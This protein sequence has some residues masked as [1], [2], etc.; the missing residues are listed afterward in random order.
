MCSLFECTSVYYTIRHYWPAAWLA[1]YTLIMK[2]LYTL[3]LTLATAYLFAQPCNISD[4]TAQVS[5]CD[6]NGQFSVTLKFFDT[7]IDTK[8]Y[9]IQGNGLNYGIFDYNNGIVITGLDGDCTT[10]YDFIVRDGTNPNCGASVEV[11]EICCGPCM[12]DVAIKSLGECVDDDNYLVEFAIDNAPINSSGYSVSFNGTTVAD[13]A[14]NDPNPVIEIKHDGEEFAEFIICDRD[15][16]TCCDSIRIVSPCVCNISNMQWDI[17]DCNEQDSTFS[18]IFSADYQV[19]SDSFTIGGNA[20]NY[21]RFAY[22]QLPLVLGPFTWQDIKYDFTIADVNNLFCF[23]FVEPGIVDI[24]PEEC[25]WQSTS[26]VYSC[27]EEDDL[28]VTVSIDNP[29]SGVLGYEVGIGG[30]FTDTLYTRDTAYSL[31]IADGFCNGAPSLIL[32]DLYYSCDTTIQLADS[33]CRLPCDITAL[34]AEVDCDSEELTINLTTTASDTRPAT[35]VLIIGGSS[36]TIATGLVGDYPL[37]IDIS[38]Y[39]NDSYVLE[40]YVDTDLCFD[41]VQFMIDCPFECTFSTVTAMVGDC[42]SQGNV[43]V[44]LNFDA[45]DMP[46]GTFFIEDLNDNVWGPFDYNTG[47]YS[48]VVPEDCSLAPTFFIEDSVDPTCGTLRS[49]LHPLCC[50]CEVEITNLEIG[51]CEDGSADITLSVSSGGA[52]ADQFTLAGNGTNYGTFDYSASPITINVPGDCVT[53]YEFVI[54]DSDDNTCMDVEELSQPICCPVDTCMITIT[55]VTIDD[56]AGDSAV[57][58]IS[59]ES[60]SIGGFELGGNGLDYGAFDYSDSPI[61]VTVNGDCSTIYEFVATDQSDSDCQAV[62]ELSDPICCAVDTCMNSISLISISD[63]MGDSSVVSLVVEGMA[64]SD[65]F[66]LNGNGISYGNFA[67]SSGAVEVVVL[68][69][70]STIYEFVATDLDDSN[71]SAATQLA[72]PICCDTTACTVEITNVEVGDCMGD[73]LTIAIIINT[74][75]TISNFFSLRGN[76]IDYGTYAYTDAPILL[77]IA[78]DCE[79]DYEFVMIDTED[80]TCLGD[81]EVEE[82]LCC[83]VDPPCAVTIDSTDISLCDEGMVDV[84]LFYSSTNA[85]SDGFTLVGNGT[86]YGTFDYDAGEVSVSLDGDCETLYEFIMTDLDNNDCQAVFG[87]TE[88]ICCDT[89]GCTLEI[90]ELEI[91]ACEEGSYSFSFDVEGVDLGPTLTLSLFGNVVDALVT[92][93]GPYTVGP[94]QSGDTLVYEVGDP[95]NDCSV[96]FEVFQDCA[97]STVNPAVAST[98]VQTIGQ[99]VRWQANSEWWHTASILNME[100]QLIQQVI[101]KS[102]SISVPQ[103]GLYLLILQNDEQRLVERVVVLE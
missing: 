49:L 102:N 2:Y 83:T 11:G 52:A 95:L 22:S 75:N 85:S 15:D 79:L 103:A 97:V 13:F 46:S 64:T 36:D 96:T 87:L 5:G 84:T 7:D 72:N 68:G 19:V 54:T 76:G 26:V 8:D 81:Y 77:T 35:A 94:I 30:L 12:L 70:C 24:C 29:G 99:E 89:V 33:C 38:D 10:F 44:T 32:N 88:P 58:T 65:S 90:F 14:Y 42:N 27:N 82:S 92:G 17:V 51:D 59:I 20:T 86:N 37:T 80:A 3:C 74:T 101:G 41:E 62:V 91:G 4:L 98:I 48:I 56:C 55:D 69:D 43:E 45:N 71:C 47:P 25:D 28:E 61:Q 31:V 57:I 23:D 60:N 6:A 63:C 73:S 53:I 16:P 50:T 21:G 9:I 78:P 100:G 66:S 1:F 40:V 67:Y 39:D 18:F 34:S 93:N